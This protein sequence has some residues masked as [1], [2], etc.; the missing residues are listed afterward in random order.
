MNGRVIDGGGIS[1][2]DKRWV[3]CRPGFFLSVRVLSRLFR[4]LFLQKL[5]AAHQAEVFARGATPQ[6]W[7]TGPPLAIRIDSS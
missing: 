2:D 6:H 3:S 7:P 1:L 5:M 4:R